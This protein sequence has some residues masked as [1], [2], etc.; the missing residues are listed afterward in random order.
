MKDLKVVMMGLGYIGLPTAALIASKKIHVLGVDVNKEIVDTIN[1]GKIHIVE[2]S[3]DGL[4]KNVVNRGFLVAS[5]KPEIADV[6]LIA[7]PTP[8]KEDY[9]ADLKYVEEATRMIIPY[10]K[11]GNLFII[12][13]TSP[14][15]TTDKMAKVIFEKRPELKGKI[16]IAYCPERVLPGRIIYELENNDRVIGGLDDFSTKSAQN[17][18]RHFVNGNQTGYKT[19]FTGLSRGVAGTTAAGHSATANIFQEIVSAV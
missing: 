15:G 16:S 6:Y 1:M 8:F 17:F 14:V 12:E 5:I 13:S 4:V 18:Y 19:S 7:V 10:L 2:P 11:D 3:L 9:K